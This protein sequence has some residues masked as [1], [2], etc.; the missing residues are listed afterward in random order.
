MELLT[1]L[2]PQTK[3][4]AHAG[5]DIW[6]NV[7]IKK[8]FATVFHWDGR[9]IPPTLCALQNSAIWHGVLSAKLTTAARYHMSLPVLTRNV[10]KGIS[11]VMGKK[12]VIMDWMKETVKVSCHTLFA[13][14]CAT[15]IQQFLSFGFIL[16]H[17]YSVSAYVSEGGIDGPECLTGQQGKSCK[18]LAYVLFKALHQV[19]DIYITSCT[20]FQGTDTI[21][22]SYEIFF[23][24][25]VAVVSQTETL[26][27]AAT[28]RVSSSH[29][30]QNLE[31]IFKNIIFQNSDLRFDNMK[32]SFENVSFVQSSMSDFVRN[33][34]T[35]VFE[36]E[37]KSHFQFVTVVCK[38]FVFEMNETPVIRV[39]VENSV[40]EK[41]SFLIK[42]D[43]I[44]LEIDGLH[45]HAVFT[46]N[47]T[48][49]TVVSI[50]SLSNVHI[51]G[52]GVTKT[53]FVL[54]VV[55][56]LG[57][58]LNSTLSELNGAVELRSTTPGFDSVYF[59]FVI[60]NCN[61]AKNFLNTSGSAL[62]VNFAVGRTH[63]KVELMFSNAT[64]VE[65]T[66]STEGS[67]AASGGA[68]AVLISLGKSLPC[69]VLTEKSLL[70][71]TVTGCLFQDNWS[72]EHGGSLY[73]S[74]LSNT[75]I[76][77]TTFVLTN[78]M[79]KK[80]SGKAM[81][82]SS[83]GQLTM[84]DTHFM[85]DKLQRSKASIL[86]LF[87]LSS[88][89]SSNEMS[90]DVLCPK[91]QDIKIAPE[92]IRSDAG[93]SHKLRGISVQCISCENGQYLPSSG[94]YTVLFRQGTSA[95]KSSGDST[96]CTACPYGAQC[97]GDGIQALPNYWGLLIGNSISFQ[98]CPPGYCCT[99][100]VAAPCDSYNL[101]SGNRTGHL[102]G[103]CKPGYS[104][105][106]F[107]G[108]CVPNEDCEDSWIWPVIAVIVIVYML[109]YTFKD[110]I[111]AI[112][113]RVCVACYK[114]L[115][116]ANTR[117]RDQR[118]N[119][120]KGYFGIVIY[121]VQIAA[122]MKVSVVLDETY[123][124]TSSLELIGSYIGQLL[125]VELSQFAYEICPFSDLSF[126]H[127]V[128]YRFLFLVSIYFSWSVVFILLYVVLTLWGKRQSW[129]NVSVAAKLRFVNGLVEIIKYT[130]SGFTGLVFLSLTCVTM[131]SKSRWLFDGT[132]E[133]LNHWQYSMFL[134]SIFYIFPMPFL[135]A[136]G[137]KL[138][139]LEKIKGY[140]FLVGCMVPL[141]FLL[142]WLCFNYKANSN[143][144][145][146]LQVVS[147]KEPDPD[148]VK[149]TNS[150]STQGS[151]A[152]TI[153]SNLQGPY[154]EDSSN[155]AMYWESVVMLRRLLIGATALINL[156]IVQ[157]MCN[158]VICTASFGHHAIVQ[159][160]IN[161]YSNWV[162]MLSLS[163]LIFV[164]L[165]NLTRSAF[166]QLGIVPI[167]PSVT[168]LKSLRFGES[169]LVLVLISFVI[170][171]E[172]KNLCSLT[173][174]KKEK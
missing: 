116:K 143:L 14:P 85:V 81:T 44:W 129:Y 93:D 101:C 13:T 26:L 91:W 119:V 34:S 95:V 108:N 30:L 79:A 59:V 28:L 158:C 49:G 2:K 54:H 46:L 19:K 74:D 50:I 170:S 123:D 55:N 32:V 36:S 157:M 141:P 51:N 98:Q 115:R 137:M 88:E 83:F 151:V 75:V 131:S 70:L 86:E 172:I 160:F 10:S 35:S 27:C 52:S 48:S 173:R 113:F 138:L 69:D 164:S 22:I 111:L 145:T 140:H 16:L 84:N 82:V 161:Y 134:F 121:F 43:S 6:R 102:C 33:T 45:G 38:D 78:K 120:D 92:Y 97:P 171:L 142:I 60:M 39:R 68:I 168:L 167:G 110:D 165:I 41:S 5:T 150:S 57:S 100:T 169:L 114:C 24:K 42:A 96:A 73:I 47:A 25:Q 155:F 61:F 112:P 94:F 21:E 104:T 53:P 7:Q 77:N 9:V 107:S 109:W 122:A 147:E 106:V 87:S 166:N 153:L 31:I 162:E 66:V 8:G 130:Y 146:T 154:K 118:E 3:P 124:G 67:E 89:F 103:E 80:P 11:I 58:I 90:I 159:P 18:T 163:L 76:S 144:V 117:K 64:F 148:E 37:P 149:S 136:F 1:V 12:I 156:P 126:T 71:I 105:S 40:L 135:L 23:P 128:M 127:S 132:V 17:H 15:S 125:T 4:H 56:V 133:C 152:E 65:N 20:A 62:S 174:K 63:D 72:D 139:K 99:G 29:D